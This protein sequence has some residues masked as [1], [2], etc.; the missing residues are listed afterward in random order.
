MLSIA[1]IIMSVAAVSMVIFRIEPITYDWMGVLVGVLSILVVT[2]IGWNIYTAVDAKTTL[3]E[4]NKKIEYYDKKLSLLIENADLQ[5]YEL[6]RNMCHTA[7]RIFYKADDAVEFLRYS[8]LGLYYTA[9]L[10]NHQQCNILIA[11]I[12]ETSSLWASKIIDVN[13]KADLLE[14]AYEIK[15][16]EVQE[17]DNV[18][19]LIMKVTT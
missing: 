10:G 6:S 2:L 3:K 18:I 17:I 8:L 16:L 5:A 13:D 11:S 14:K 15:K 1:A 4:Q 9:K 12:L 7:S 19:M